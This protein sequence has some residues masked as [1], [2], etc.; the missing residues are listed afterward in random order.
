[1][2]PKPKWSETET[3][4]WQRESSVVEQ[5]GDALISGV[6]LSNVALERKGLKRWERGP[7]EASGNR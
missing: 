3:A 4:S 2:S 5:R 6:V 7:V 1:M